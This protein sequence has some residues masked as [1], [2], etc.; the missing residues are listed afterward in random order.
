MAN[1]APILPGM[2]RFYPRQMDHTINVR[3]FILRN[4]TPY[5]GDESFLAPPT[6]AT[7]TLWDQ[8]M[9]LSKKEREAGGVLD[10]EHQNCL[11]HH[12]PRP[13]LFE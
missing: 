11:H 4:I 12:Q 8:V 7:K 9:E 5:D 6:Q 3:D 13:R 10:M 1:E 2:G